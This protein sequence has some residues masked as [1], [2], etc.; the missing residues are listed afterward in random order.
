MGSEKHAGGLVFSW[1]N[2]LAFT[3][4]GRFTF[5]KSRFAKASFVVLY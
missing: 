1:S 5:L 4:I 2:Q 3:N